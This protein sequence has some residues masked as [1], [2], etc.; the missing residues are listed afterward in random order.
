M[1]HQTELASPEALLLASNA[2]GTCAWQSD[3]TAVGSVAATSVP[4]PC[5]RQFALRGL[6]E[7]PEL[8]NARNA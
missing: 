1:A 3:T 2:S 5:P 4:P 8:Y 7:A 6:P